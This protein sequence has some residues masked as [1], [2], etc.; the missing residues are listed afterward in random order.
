MPISTSIKKTLRHFFYLL[1]NLDPRDVSLWQGEDGVS[2]EFDGD[3]PCVHYSALDVVSTYLISSPIFTL[4]PGVHE[5]SLRG[6]ITSGLCSFG[7]LDVKQDSWAANQPIRN[8]DGRS[9]V[10]V[11]L[12]RKTQMQ[13]IISSDN[14][15]NPGPVNGVLSRV[16][17][18]M[19]ADRTAA[20]EMISKDA[21]QANLSQW[22]RKAQ[23][24]QLLDA[25]HA[26]VSSTQPR[27]A[28]SYGVVGATEIGY[29][30]RS[31]TN[32]QHD[33]VLYTLVANAGDDTVTV[34]ERTRPGDA[35]KWKCDLQFPQYS[36]PIDVQA[37]ATEND[38]MIGVSFFHMQEI[39]SE[40]GLTGFGMVS[41]NSI[42]DRAKT[43]Q[44]VEV[45]KSE[46][47]FL[48]QRGS[49]RGARNAAVVDDG[50][51]RW[52]A[53]TDRDRSA[54]WVF[55]Q[56][57]KGKEWGTPPSLIPLIKSFE[58]VGIT[59]IKRGQKAVFYA[60]ARL[61]PQIATIEVTGDEPPKV[62]AITEV[63]GLSRSSIAI[64]AFGAEKKLGLAVGLWG[65][66]PTN[67]T[68]P[69]QGSV[70]IADI[71]DDGTLTNHAWFDAGI[72]T[73]DVVAGDL[74]G[75]GEDEL[76]VLNYGN[77]LNLETRSHLGDLQIFKRTTGGF[78]CVAQL[79]IP[80][81]RI[82]SVT[83]FDGDGKPELG[84]TLF[85]EKRLAIIKY[86]A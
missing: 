29:A 64:G 37:I 38:H 81:P 21:E 3:Q 73:T 65:G 20:E 23:P 6:E 76:A 67:I 45:E 60:S 24:K 86:F 43:N 10:L 79:D 80:S 78:E 85:H 61:L 54:V 58:P 1:C 39:S 8:L 22:R 57:Y 40:F 9:R 12:A 19:K 53:V 47:H 77:G 7:V 59:G 4:P 26:E 84:V 62:M 35:L 18:E 15:D 75:D 83:D 52:M 70:F 55:H 41:L 11:P 72:N 44:K 66:D 34:L 27:R 56:K 32:V 36:T 14:A 16:K 17:V 31:I 2:L 49:F 48:H 63:G 33:D 13:L 50:E 42:L 25:L 46:I 74:D 30:S 5:I 68:I 69:Y 71:L 28:K 82:G 51:Q